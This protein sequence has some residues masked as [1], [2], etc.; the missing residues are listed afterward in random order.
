MSAVAGVMG[1]HSPTVAP[2]KTAPNALAVFPSIRME[3]P[4]L[5]IFSRWNGS[6]HGRFAL[7]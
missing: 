6:G 5:S 2:A 7:A 3:S 4:V 1:Y